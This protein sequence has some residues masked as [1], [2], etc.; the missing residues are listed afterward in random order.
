MQISVSL[1]Y[2]LRLGPYWH[3]CGTSLLT[4]A[5]CCSREDRSCFTQLSTAWNTFSS[6]DTLSCPDD[7]SSC[8]CAAGMD[9]I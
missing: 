6:L 3:Y 4:L 5:T 8:T 9:Y 1:G 7:T 2:P